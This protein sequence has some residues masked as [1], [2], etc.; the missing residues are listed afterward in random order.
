MEEQ[1]ISS[2]LERFDLFVKYSNLF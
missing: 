1:E 2:T